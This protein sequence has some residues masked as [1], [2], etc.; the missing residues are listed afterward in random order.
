MNAR[1]TGIISPDPRG[2]DARSESGGTPVFMDRPTG[3][4]ERSLSSIPID[5]TAEEKRLRGVLSFLDTLPRFP[6]SQ[7]G[8]ILRLFEKGGEKPL[9]LGIPTVTEPPGRPAR[10]LSEEGARNT[11]PN[12]SCF[13]RLTEDQVA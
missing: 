11:E 8:N 12:R 13:S 1:E 4:V 5:P 10:R 6:L 9:Q 3:P 2:S 7:P